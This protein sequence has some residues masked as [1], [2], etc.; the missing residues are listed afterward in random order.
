MAGYSFRKAG[1]LL[2]ESFCTEHAIF[3]VQMND[4]SRDCGDGWYAIEADLHF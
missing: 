2:E 3:N 1:Q 4:Y